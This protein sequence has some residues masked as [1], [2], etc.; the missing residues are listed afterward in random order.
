MNS[1]KQE[2]LR[3]WL[4]K[5]EEDISV[6][7]ILISEHPEHYTG[8]ICFHAQQ[9]VE[10]FLKAI[11]VFYDFDFK[12]VHDLDYLLQEC[13]KIDSKDFE[14]I[15]LESLTDYGVSVRYPDDF[16]VPSVAEALKYQ[17]IAE[18]I[19]NIVLRKIVLE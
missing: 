2:Y 19:R 11:L 3:N 12:K 15:D 5:A 10:K 4:F 14:S 6:I 1:G 7:K 13:I 18:E 16:L 8:A 17:Q 9:A